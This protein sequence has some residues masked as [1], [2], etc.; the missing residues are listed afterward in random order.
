M[1]AVDDP[2]SIAASL[3]GQLADVKRQMKDLSVNNTQALTQALAAAS[4]ASAAASAAATAASNARINVA[5]G[6]A[7]ASNYLITTSYATI[8][9][10]GLTVPSGYTRAL[11]SVSAFATGLSAASSLDR[12]YV[13]AV[14]NGVAGPQGIAEMVP[15]LPIVGASAFQTQSL[16]GLTAGSTISVSV[17]ARL[18]TGPGD[19]PFTNASVSAMAIF[20]V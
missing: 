10:F 3:P 2:F 8:A 15:S 18:G 1:P 9:S 14:S 11:V 19:T 17:Q 4:A 12:I 5:V 16:S 6:N 13:Q 20:Q 7:S